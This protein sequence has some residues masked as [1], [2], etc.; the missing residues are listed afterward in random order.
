[1]AAGLGIYFFYGRFH[2]LV[3]AASND[4]HRASMS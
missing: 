4:R 1:M 2:S 3:D